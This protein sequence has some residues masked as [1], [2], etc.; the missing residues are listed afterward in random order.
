M[1]AAPERG[2]GPRLNCRAL[3]WRAASGSCHGNAFPITG[4]DQGTDD[5]VVGISVVARRRFG[6]WPWRALAGA[7][8]A[9]NSISERCGKHA[10]RD[11]RST[12]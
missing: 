3:L 7:R 2:T 1:R 10:D 9:A 12:E 4:V 5:F 11:E 6:Y 8:Y